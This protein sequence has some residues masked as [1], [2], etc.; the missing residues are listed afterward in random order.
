MCQLTVVPGRWQGTEPVRKRDKMSTPPKIKPHLHVVGIGASA[1]GLDA[2]ERFFANMVPDVEAAYVVVTHLN[3][4]HVSLLPKLLAKT[5]DLNVFQAQDAAVVAPGNVYVISPGKEMRI[6]DGCLVLGDLRDGRRTGNLVD[7]FF[8]SLARDRGNTAIGIILSGTGTDGTLGI[9]ALKKAGAMV[10]AQDIASAEYEDMPRSA[11]DTGLV[12]CVSPP[13][14]LPAILRN[15]IAE[16]MNKETQEVQVE[17]AAKEDAIKDVISIL[18]AE[19]SH[20][21]TLYKKNTIARRIERRMAVHQLSDLADYVRLL[22]DSRQEA[23]TL[24]KELLIGVTSFFRDPEAF[25]VLKKKHLPELLREKRKDHTLR[26]W[27]PGCSTGEEAYSIAIVIAECL[28]QEKGVFNVQIFATDLDET[29]I[30]IARNGVYAES[31]S[32][33]MSGERL[34]NYFD[35]VGNKY[36]IKKGIREM[37]TFAQQNIIKDPPF[38]KIDLLCCRNLLIYFSPELQKKLIPLF[39]YSLKQP[40]LLFIGS[41]ET[42]GI[43]HELF[44]PLDKKYKIFTRKESELSPYPLMHFPGSRAV[45]RG[46]DKKHSRQSGVLRNASTTKMLKMILTESDMPPC[47]IVNGRKDILYIHGRVG[48]F[49]ELAEGKPSLNLIKMARPGIIPGMTTA[50]REARDTGREVYL[51]NVY[52]FG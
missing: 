17:L 33:S 23:L 2:L 21:F 48:Q 6:A 35:L 30:D 12:D 22:K 47:V 7:V 4:D 40:G 29:A 13:E 9:H 49:L 5:T 26:V 52:L 24:F 32:A 51:E 28:M 20:D 31:I 15:H 39:H 38:T 18:R 14:Q 43:F 3:P 42:I 45:S 36:H 16:C 25:D 44:S 27:V 37:V 41:S 8:E 1:G 34:V 19:T 10:M 50:F 11:I 46:Q